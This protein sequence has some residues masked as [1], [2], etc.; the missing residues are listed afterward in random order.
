MRNVNLLATIIGM[1]IMP[2]ANAATV[3]FSPS[4]V[5]RILKDSAGTNLSTSSL[6]WAGNFTSESF[7]LNNALTISQNV[8]AIQAAGGWEQFGVDTATD[9]ANAGVTGALSVNIVASNPRLGGAITDNN[10]GST[11]ADYFN[12]KNLYVWIFNASTVGGAT[13]MGIF[14]ATPW[15]FPTNAG[16]VNDTSTFGTTVSVTP[17]AVGGIGSTSSTLLQLSG[18]APVPEPSTFATGAM[19]ILTAMKMRRRRGA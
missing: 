13:E 9:V 11:K 18:I 5:A 16:G 3:G 17:A 1:A 8:A 2:L 4:P 10:F 19:L 7:S 14:K 12:A 6:V 15:V